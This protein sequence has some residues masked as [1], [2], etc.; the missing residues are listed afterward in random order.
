MPGQ[1]LAGGSL[2][3]TPGP[4]VFGNKE[5]IPLVR[6]TAL[7]GVVRYLIILHTSQWKMELVKLPKTLLTLEN[8]VGTF[9]RNQFNLS[10][11]PFLIVALKKKSTVLKRHF[12]CKKNLP[13]STPAKQELLEICLFKT[14]FLLFETVL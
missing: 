12:R 7:L 5:L 1:H 14:F 9:I 10:S 13:K 3:A 8:P 2:L 11:Q 4:F 6:Q